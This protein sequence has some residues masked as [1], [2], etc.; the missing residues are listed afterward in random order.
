M[1][2]R[3]YYQLA[4]EWVRNSGPVQLFRYYADYPAAAVMYAAGSRAHKAGIAAA[5]NQAYAPLCHHLTQRIGRVKKLTVY[6]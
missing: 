4:A 6:I 1:H 2:I 5:K 3:R